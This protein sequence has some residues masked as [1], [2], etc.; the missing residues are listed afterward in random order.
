MSLVGHNKVYKHTPEISKEGWSL[1]KK[2]NEK[3]QAMAS[4][5][6]KERTGERW[7]EDRIK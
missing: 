3:K 5:M 6:H 4:K 1:P 7:K 2:G